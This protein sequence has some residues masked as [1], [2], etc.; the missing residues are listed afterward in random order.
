M[1]FDWP[2]YL[3][4]ARL[5][6]QG[7]LDGSTPEA[8]SRCAVSRAYYAAFCHARNY[9]RDRLGFVPDHTGADHH[10]VQERLRNRGLREIVRGLERLRQWR[11]QCDYHDHVLNLAGIVPQAL[12]TAR[13]VIESLQ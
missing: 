10:R 2:E 4:L 8:A 9:A 7:G 11:G 13:Q 6:A 1:A 12:Q 3:E 5:L